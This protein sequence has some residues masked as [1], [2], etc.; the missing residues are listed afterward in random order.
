MIGGKTATASDRSNDVLKKMVTPE[1]PTEQFLMMGLQG[2]D[3][4]IR[5]ARVSR[6]SGQQVAAP[7]VAGGLL[8]RGFEASDPAVSSGRSSVA[9][10]I[11]TDPVQAIASSP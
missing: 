11:A 8:A 5:S 3:D 6:S 9:K 1:A 7:R 4:V 2:T 10:G